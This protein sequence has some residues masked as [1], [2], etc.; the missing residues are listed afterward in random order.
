MQPI[1]VFYDGWCPLCTA[2][3]QRLARLDWLG[4]LEF[5][6]IR[7]PGVAE[8]AGVAPERLAAR[9]H[10]HTPRTGRWAEGIWAVAAI[11]ARLP[12]LW[13]LWPLLAL[14]GVTGLGQPLYDFI[15]RRRAIVPV[16]QCDETGCPLPGQG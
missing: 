14:A 2:A 9:L 13:P 1:T 15:A 10:V 3:R 11:A 16:G 7:D 5:V 6:S 8:R 12:L 4:R